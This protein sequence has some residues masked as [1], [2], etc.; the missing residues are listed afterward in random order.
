MI[1]QPMTFKRASDRADPI[2]RVAPGKLSY[3]EQQILDAVRAIQVALPIRSRRSSSAACSVPAP[4][5][6]SRT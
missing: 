4:D 6:R 5:L 2:G 1:T 3:R